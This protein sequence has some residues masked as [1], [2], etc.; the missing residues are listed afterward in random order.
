MLYLNYVTIAENGNFTCYLNDKMIQQNKVIVEILYSEQYEEW[1]RHVTY[2]LYVVF[3]CFIILVGGIAIG[4]L[5][6]ENFRKI[7]TQEM[8]EMYATRRFEYE[9]LLPPSE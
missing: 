2:L 8:I 4:C 1:W 5:Q 7:N 6:K 3:M 9:R